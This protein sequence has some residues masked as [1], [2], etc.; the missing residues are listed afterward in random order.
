MVFFGYFFELR[1]IQQTGEVVEV[2]H[3][4]V[5]AMFTEERHVLAEIHVFQMIGDKAAIAALDALAEFL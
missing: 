4:L 2:E 3:V 5:L 1:Y